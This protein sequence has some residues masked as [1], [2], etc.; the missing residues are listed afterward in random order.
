MVAN[1]L[2][3]SSDKTTCLSFD[4]RNELKNNDIK[5]INI[6][7]DATTSINKAKNFDVY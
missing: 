5:H 6:E 2:P 4:V 3:L 7:H 1:K